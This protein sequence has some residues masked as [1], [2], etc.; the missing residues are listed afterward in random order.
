MQEPIEAGR[1]SPGRSGLRLG[2][3]AAVVLVLI[4][5][6]MIAARAPAVRTHVVEMRGMQFAPAD[7][8]VQ[9][10]DSVVWVNRDQVP[11]NVTG[12]WSS[13]TIAAGARWRT[14]ARTGGAYACTLHP[15]MRGRVAVE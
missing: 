12:A 2:M 5:V 1:Q 10:G 3:S 7:L 13:G 14:V 8:T 15:G 9:R 4:I 6:A 11:H